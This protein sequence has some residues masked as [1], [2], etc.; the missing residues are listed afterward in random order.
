MPSFSRQSGQYHFARR[1]GISSTV[2]PTHLKWNHSLS[3]LLSQEIMSPYAMSLQIQYLSSSESFSSTSLGWPSGFFFR[4]ILLPWDRLTCVTVFWPFSAEVTSPFGGG[5]RRALARVGAGAVSAD[6]LKMLCRRVSRIGRPSLGLGSSL[7]AFGVGTW[8]RDERGRKAMVG[9]VEVARSAPAV[10]VVLG[11]DGSTGGGLEFLGVIDLRC[12]RVEGAVGAGCAGADTSATGDGILA[13]KGEG[14]ADGNG[15]TGV[16]CLLG[17]LASGR[18]STSG[19]PGPA[20][21]S[22]TWT[23]SELSSGAGV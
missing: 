19:V 16:A 23:V 5:F 17:S 18:S 6:W 8:L 20:G 13:S 9:S 2:M 4:L 1:P 3:Q 7:C 22:G 21:A 12:E 14:G 10:R 15:C 11:L